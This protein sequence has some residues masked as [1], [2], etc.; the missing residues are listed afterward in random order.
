MSQNLAEQSDLIFVI[1]SHHTKKD[2]K[3]LENAS[4]VFLGSIFYERIKK[5]LSEGSNFGLCLVDEGRE[6]P[7]NSQSGLS[8]ACQRAKRLFMAFRWR[9]D[10]GP[11]VSAGLVAMP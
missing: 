5:D 6:D 1:H 3:R 11:T 7:S 10:D 9:A 4:L 2:I 8:T